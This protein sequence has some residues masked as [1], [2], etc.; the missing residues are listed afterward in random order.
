MKDIKRLIYDQRAAATAIQALVTLL[1]FTL[2]FA[3]IIDVGYVT[4]VYFDIKTQMDLANRAVYKNINADRLAEREF[5]IDESQGWQTFL[6]KLRTNM[7]L[8]DEMNPRADN[9]Y[10]IVGTV[11]VISFEIYNQDELPAVTPAG[12]H[13]D[14]VSVHSRVEVRIRPLFIWFSEITVRPHIDTDIPDKLLLT[15]HP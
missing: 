5:Y 1:I 13:V 2:L 9:E 14:E 4:Y 8:D 6:E 12:T 7:K 10:R 15:Y 3:L 11:N